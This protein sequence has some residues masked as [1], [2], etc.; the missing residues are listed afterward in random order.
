MIPWESKITLSKM[1]MK[2]I[3]DDDDAE[4]EIKYILEEWI[5]ED[6]EREKK[7]VDHTKNDMKLK[8]S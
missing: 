7:T 5:E 2:K 1:K 3:A 8:R 6:T 4:D